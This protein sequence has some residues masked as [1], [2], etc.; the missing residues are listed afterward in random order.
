[1]LFSL[2]MGTC[3]VLVNISIKEQSFSAVA[4]PG[5]PRTTF[6]W[7]NRYL[8]NAAPYKI[9]DPK[10]LRDIEFCQSIKCESFKKKQKK[11]EVNTQI[12]KRPSTISSTEVPL[13]LLRF[14]TDQPGFQVAP[15]GTIERGL[16]NVSDFRVGLRIPSLNVNR[17]DMI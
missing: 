10:K 4:G 9:R 17:I 1:M 5:K 8:L 15:E 2:P 6:L 16:L 7:A 13:H 11:V 14:L 3:S 12:L